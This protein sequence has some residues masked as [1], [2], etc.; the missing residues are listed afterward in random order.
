M[1]NC[2][3]L[4]AADAARRPLSSVVEGLSAQ[5]SEVLGLALQGVRRTTIA[6]ELELSEDTVTAELSEALRALGVADR[7]EAVYASARL[8][9]TVAARPL[10]HAR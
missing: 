6:S 7:T 3:P 10:A 5:Q 8:G 2:E 9:V 1:I 4:A